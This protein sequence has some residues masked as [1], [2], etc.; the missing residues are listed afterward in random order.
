MAK[1]SRSSTSSHRRRESRGDVKNDVRTESGA[2]SLE[3]GDDEVDDE[4]VL[5]NS[6]KGFANAFR[7]LY[8]DKTRP[9]SEE[10]G[11]SFFPSFLFL[12]FGFWLLFFFFFFLRR[13]HRWMS[14][15]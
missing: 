10:V 5:A 9:E 1:K 14:I 8:E 4:A 12:G 15:A 3:D 7:E 11:S 6:G 13:N 2:E